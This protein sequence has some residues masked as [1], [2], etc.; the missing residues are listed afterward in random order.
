MPGTLRVIAHI[1]A[2]PESIKKLKAVLTGLIEPTRREAG[3]IRYELW[4][5][6][7][8]PTDFTFVEEWANEASLDAHL[9]SR[10]IAD[11]FAVAGH[12]LD[13]EIDLRRY[14]PVE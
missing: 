6:S 12:M 8:T 3:C 7:E 11:A 13:G 14:H 5:N 2:R 4:H 10:H 1:P 9:Q